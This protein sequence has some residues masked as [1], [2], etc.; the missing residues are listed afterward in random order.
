MGKRIFDGNSKSYRDTYSMITKGNNMKAFELYFDYGLYYEH[1]IS[2]DYFGTG[3]YGK[4]KEKVTS[5]KEFGNDVLICDALLLEK[6]DADLLKRI[7]YQQTDER[8]SEEEESELRSYLRSEVTVFN[9]D[10]EADMLTVDEITETLF[11]VH[12]DVGR[13]A[14]AYRT[15]FGEN[16]DYGRERVKR[17]M[18]G[19]EGNTFFFDD[20]GI[21]KEIETH[22]KRYESADVRYIMN[23]LEENIKKMFVEVNE[24]LR[25]N[26]RTDKFKLDV[27]SIT[28]EIYRKFC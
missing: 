8:M 11:Y 10:M 12:R 7:P 9:E 1:Y 25:K 5:F 19:Y 13:L 14:R 15:C 22:S 3:L 28:V 18:Y 21:A 16:I 24:L 20:A 23:G 27:I 4:E 17:L 2:D 6:T 26:S